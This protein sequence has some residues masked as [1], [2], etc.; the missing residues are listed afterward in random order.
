MKKLGVI[1]GGRSV[2]H[3][4]SIISALQAI[5]NIDKQKY[6]VIPLYIGKNNKW[7]SDESLLNIE[8]FKDI[9]NINKLDVVNLQNIE[10][11]IVVKKI[12]KKLFTSS[13]VTDLD[14]VLPIV[15]GTNVED[16]KLQGFLETIGAIYGGPSVYSAVVGQDKALM[17][18]LLKAN[19]INQIDYFWCY[20]NE[21]I[22]SI[23]NKILDT[24]KYPVIIKPALLGSS[25]GIEVIENYE[26]LINLL[27]QS[28]SYCNKMVIEKF[29]SNFIEM[30]ISLLG[31]YSDFEFSA[32]E[33]VAKSD[34][35]LSFEDKYMS[36]SKKSSGMASLER[37]VP[38]KISSSLEEKI[39]DITAKT[40][41]VLNVQGICRIDLIIINEEV[42]IN[43]INNIPGSLSFYLW[44]AKGVSYSELLDKIIN[45]GATSYFKQ[46]SLNCSFDTNVLNI[47]A[48]GVKK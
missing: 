6:E 11:K 47:S 46:Q 36:G 33:Q 37:I 10:N 24:I 35:I 45:I 8:T 21:N 28:F 9:E 42:Y 17:K 38:A 30:N 16:G 7:Y 48:K 15:H 4:I 43:E 31:T 26:Q 3:E 27:P 39:H 1:F 20:D 23:H 32:I 14:F 25:V 2:E 29:C 19:Q 12:K 22:E 40:F 13:I 44:E 34:E 41:S 18:D 5:E